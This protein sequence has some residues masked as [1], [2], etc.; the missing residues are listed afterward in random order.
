MQKGNAMEWSWIELKSAARTKPFPAAVV[1]NA[2]M[3]ALCDACD[4]LRWSIEVK[5]T[6]QSDEVKSVVSESGASKMQK[7]VLILC[8]AA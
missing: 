6:L 3:G 8:H 4:A 7:T 1:A 2:W 5:K